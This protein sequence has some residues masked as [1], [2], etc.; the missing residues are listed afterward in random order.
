MR[1]CTEQYFLYDLTPQRI[2][3]EIAY[4]IHMDELAI[5]NFHSAHLKFY[6]MLQGCFR[7]R[8]EVG[9]TFMKCC[10]FDLGQDGKLRK[11]HFPQKRS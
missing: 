9:S 5:S 3:V 6:C 2:L 11:V 8:H 1:F 10:H 4:L 7:Q